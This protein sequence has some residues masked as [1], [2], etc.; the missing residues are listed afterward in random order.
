MQWQHHHC[1]ALVCLSVLRAAAAA[2]AAVVWQ[3][4]PQVLSRPLQ[5]VVLMPA[6][7]GLLRPCPSPAAAA[8]L[9]LQRWGQQAP[10]QP[11]V[12]WQEQLSAAVPAGA[13]AAA[14]RHPPGQQVLAALLAALVL[15]LHW[16]Q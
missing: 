7:L 11:Q 9:W 16:R 8:A 15:L 1:L 3:E 12:R 10:L 4:P 6:L 2:A 5:A 13:A 14:A